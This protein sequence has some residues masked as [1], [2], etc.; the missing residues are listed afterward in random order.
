MIGLVERYRAGLGCWLLALVA[1][2]GGSSG[3][4]GETVGNRATPFDLPTVISLGG[5]VLSAPRVQ[6]IYFPGFDLAADIDGFLGGL[7][8]SAY[9]QQV[10]AEYG[11]GRLT[12]SASHTSSV[13]APRTLDIGG[14]QALL[15][16]VF[17]ADT[18]VL[19]APRRDTIYAVFFPA[20]TT[21]TSAGATLCQRQAP[22]GLHTEMTLAGTGVAVAVIP[23]CASAPERPDLTGAAALTPTVS[24]ELIESATDPFLGSAPAFADTDEQH[25]IWSVALSGGEVADLCENEQPNLVVPPELGLPVQRIW[26]NAAVAAGAGPCVPVPAGETYFNAVGRLPDSVSIQ[27]RGETLSVPALELA[28]GAAGVVSADLRGQLGS[29][30]S[31]SVAAVEL[32]A[33]SA[34]I[35]AFM[36]VVGTLGETLSIPVTAPSTAI[37]TFPLLILSV[38]PGARHLWVGTVQRR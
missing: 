25:A 1:G 28:A 9:W 4:G 15:E 2:C 11:V 6:A 32:H 38:S 34:S 7:G 29:P 36:P 30:A 33:S 27:R 5:P 8:G 13:A 18:A 21:L 24:H 26:S 16:Q 20:S 31:W 37:G 17:G 14:V 23:E 19:G 22:T 3:G 12:T 35:P 10:T